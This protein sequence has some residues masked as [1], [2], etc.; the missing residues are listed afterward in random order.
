MTTIV[1]GGLVTAE[2]DVAMRALKYADY[3]VIGEGEITVC[4]LADAL[5][6]GASPDGVDGLIFKRDGQYVITAPREEIADIDSIPWPDYE[7]FELDK[8]LELPPRTSII[9]AKHD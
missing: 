7:G 1:G 6:H 5:E 3:G 4:E 9:L 2:P 8:Y